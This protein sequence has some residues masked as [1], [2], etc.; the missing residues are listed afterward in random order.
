MKII[1]T[2]LKMP[3]VKQLMGYCDY[4]S[5]EININKN[6]K[7]REKVTTFI[8]EAIHYFIDKYKISKDLHFLNDIIT[9]IFTIKS[10]RKRK[11]IITKYYNYYYKK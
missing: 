7:L 5:R 3:G 11:N 1:I 10:P 6:L 4:D 2:D 9:I 8:H